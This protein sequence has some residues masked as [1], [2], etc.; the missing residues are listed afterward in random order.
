MVDFLTVRKGFND[1]WML[2]GLFLFYAR[3]KLGLGIYCGEDWCATMH[4]KSKIFS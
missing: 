3:K 1:S 4:L 2:Y